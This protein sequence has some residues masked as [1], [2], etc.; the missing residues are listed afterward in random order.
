MDRLLPNRLPPVPPLG[1]PINIHLTAVYETAGALLRE[2]SRAVNRGATQL[3]SESGLPV[4]T[5]FTLGLATAA[6]PKPIVVAGVVTASVRRGRAFHMLLRYDFDPSQS[7][8]LLD[9][10]LALAR[11]EAPPRGPRREARIPLTLGVEA[12]GL[13]GVASEVLNLSRRGCRLELRGSGVPALRAG[14]PLRMTVSGRGRGRRVTLD[15]EVRWVRGG[16][17]QRR[18]LLGAAFVGLTPEARARL[19]A[20]LKLQDLRPKIRVQRVKAKARSARAKESSR[21]GPA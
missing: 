5:R 4:G 15:L 20:I 12:G 13:R 6:L 10:V 7:R 3:R 18:L 14:D 8:P 17:R 1:K 19:L 21:E 16:R 2:L 9:S 11:R